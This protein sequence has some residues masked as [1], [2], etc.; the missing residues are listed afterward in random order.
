MQV[1]I[2]SS[3]MNI[4]QSDF[5]NDTQDEILERESLLMPPAPKKYLF[6][7]TS[8]VIAGHTLSEPNLDQVLFWFVSFL[9][10]SCSFLGVT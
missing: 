3:T 5:S 10:P 1:V 9:P 7:S 6:N 8:T 2:A 4:P